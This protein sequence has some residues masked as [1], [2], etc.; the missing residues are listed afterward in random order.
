VA[1]TTWGHG[2]GSADS[3]PDEHGGVAGFWTWLI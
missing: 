1:S 2:E 3:L